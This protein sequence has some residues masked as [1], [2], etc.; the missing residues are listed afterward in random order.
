VA[1]LPAA[2]TVAFFV[3]R[4]DVTSLALL[5]ERYALAAPVYTENVQIAPEKQFVLYNGTVIRE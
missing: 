5:R 3:A 4:D 2:G 1:G